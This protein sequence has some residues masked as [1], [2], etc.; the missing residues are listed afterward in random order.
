MRRRL[1][2]RCIDGAPHNFQV[3]IDLWVFCSKCL[4]I[5]E[6]I[7]DESGG[8]PPDP[9]D[10]RPVIVFNATGGDDTQALQNF[11]NGQGN[12]VILDIHGVAGIGGQGVTIQ[13]KIGVKITSTTGG[14][15]KAISDGQYS[16]PYSSM[17]YG[18]NLTE[19][20]FEDLQLDGNGKNAQGLYLNQCVRS[21]MLRLH[22]WNIRHAASGPPYAALKAD[23]SVDIEV[24]HC[25]VHDL[26]GAGGNGEGV[27]GI[28]LGVGGSFCVRPYIHDCLVVN[29]GHSGI[30]TESSAPRV[31]NN[32]V[33]EVVIDGTGYKFI[34]RGDPAEADYS[35]NYVES[36]ANGGFMIEGSDVHPTKIYVRNW[37]AR[38]VGGMGTSFGMLYVSG[39]QGVRNVVGENWNLDGCMRIANFNYLFDSTFKD[40]VVNDGPP[41]SALEHE[42]H[43]IQF[44]NAGT[45]EIG[46]NVTQI[47]VDGKQVV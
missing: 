14:G 11:I 36:T 40:I 29:P 28:W 47:W 23:S 34:A 41:V 17:L 4:T 10:G 3:L 8:S 9:S 24:G 13:S 35:D 33:H 19:C 30:V 46:S 2:Q 12:N 38:D 15:C 31:V 18:N 21:K 42:V 22:A 16:T 25:N 7:V 45:V 26:S 39:S 37:V 20:T 6:L 44:N 43:N 5:T 27:R 1:T 32:K